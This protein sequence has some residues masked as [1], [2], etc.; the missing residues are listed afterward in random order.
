[1][2][3]FRKIF[4]R[5][6]PKWMGSSDHSDPSR[7]TTDQSHSKVQ[8]FQHTG[9]TQFGITELEDYPDI[10]RGQNGQASTTQSNNSDTVRSTLENISEEAILEQGKAT[11]ITT[12][13]LGHGQ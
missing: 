1:M 6:A 2:P 13:Q 4:K 7:P 5:F 11:Y 8:R 3:T 9:Y 10:E 12:T